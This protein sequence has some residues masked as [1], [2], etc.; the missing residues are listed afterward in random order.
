M[1]YHDP[2][3]TTHTLAAATLSS[4]ADLLMVTGPRGHQGRLVGI[5]AVVTTS[6]TV[7]ATELRVGDA[8]DA[9]QYGI[10]SVPVATAGAA[11]VYNE[12]T[13]YDV[14]TNLMPADTTVIIATD[15]GCTAGAADV[16]V[17]IAWFK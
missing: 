16:S 1:S 2:V 14:D 8:A 6:T 15:G 4:A 11:A 5:S 3:Y 13:I 12:A 10:I 9:D 17:I 7:A